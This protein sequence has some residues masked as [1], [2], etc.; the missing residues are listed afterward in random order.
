MCIRDRSNVESDEGTDDELDEEENTNSEPQS[1]T[2][3]LKEQGIDSSLL[4]ILSVFTLLV[5]IKM[6]F[7]SRKIKKLKKELG[8]A[9][10]SNNVWERLDFDG[11]GEISDLEFEAYKVIRDEGKQPESSNKQDGDSDDEDSENPTLEL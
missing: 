6:T 9:V 3:F 10:G 5:I 1:W 2:E 8:D 4:I 7:S 11:D